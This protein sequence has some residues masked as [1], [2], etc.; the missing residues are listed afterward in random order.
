MEW[1]THRFELSRGTSAH[2][3]R[4][5][6][7][8][9]GFAVLLVFLVHYVTLAKPWFS[10][11]S[12]LAL[13]SNALHAIGS[14]G[15]DLFFVLS[16]YLIYGT[17]IS[18]QQQFLHFMSRRVRRIYPAFFAVFAAYVA[19]S[20]IFPAEKKIPAPVL[21]GI[22]YLIQNFF[23]LPGL[24]PIE[25][26]ITVAWSLSYEMLYYFA[27]PL[28]ITLFRLRER[29]A[30]WR[31][32]FFLTMA[33]L[34]TIYCAEYG[35]HIRLVMFI[36]G[37]LLH[38][39]IDNRHIP[40]PHSFFGLFALAL[41][42]LGTLL[43]QDGPRDLAL[44]TSI[45][46]ASFFLLCLVCFRDPSAWLPSIFSWTPLRWLGNMSYSYYLLHGLALKA[47]FFV[48]A[49]TLPIANHGAFLFLALLLAMFG[50]TLIPTTILFL[51]V[52]RPFSL[53]PHRA[54]NHAPEMGLSEGL[55]S[56]VADSRPVTRRLP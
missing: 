13:F 15:V 48:L 49:I 50:L 37:I 30:I 2:N 28:V 10:G 21:D 34:F 45:L 3:V 4:P 32:L 46:F 24:F 54:K 31:V 52:E 12:D 38:E 26:M 25:P 43:P 55:H 14:T 39:A 33:S 35:G 18:R 23:L 47:G 7:G 27:I 29:S 5:M 22:I 8:L 19:L 41:V 9:R 1:L 40:A 44:K 53:V 51:A 20:F 36:S 17:L 11:N 16:G 42:V 56:A 6:E